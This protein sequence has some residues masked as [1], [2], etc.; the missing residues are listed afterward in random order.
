MDE[1]NCLTVRRIISTN[2]R[3]DSEAFAQHLLD[4]PSCKSYYDKQ[5]KFNSTL[6]KALEIDVPEGLAE[7]VLLEVNL[8]KKKSRKENVRWL[9]VAASVLVV[10]IVFTTTTLHSPPALAN[11][12][13]EHVKYDVAAFDIRTDISLDELNKLLKP[14]GVR[15][16]AGIGDAT[17][18][19]ICVINGKQGAHVVFEG[20][21]SP[22]TMII[23]PQHLKVNESV[24][25]D[26]KQYK[27]MLLGTKKGTLA[28][29][30][31][32][33]ESLS[34]FETKMRK[35]LMTFI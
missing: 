11:A 27:G 8:S 6:K 14:H 13:L 24:I 18:A 23:T 17:S 1:M 15:A 20:K 19:G 10:F 5:Q 2:V 30:S 25:I 33:Q 31:E 35:H 28:V 4:C 7:R 32:D 22:V 34:Q 3:D 26:D 21:N 9:A 29:I 16:D 12:I